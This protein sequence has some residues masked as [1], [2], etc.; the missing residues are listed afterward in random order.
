[1]KLRLQIFRVFAPHWSLACCLVSHERVSD[2][3]GQGIFHLKSQT[4][5]PWEVRL[6]KFLYVNPISDARDGFCWTKHFLI[7]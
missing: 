6:G 1:M 3:S 7:H 2:K 4:L 5:R